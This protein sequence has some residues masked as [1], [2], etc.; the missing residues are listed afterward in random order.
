MTYVWV[1]QKDRREGRKRQEGREIY[2]KI[3]CK[4]FGIF[5]NRW[6]LRDN[7]HISVLMPEKKAGNYFSGS[8]WVSLNLVHS[9]SNTIR[10]KWK[11]LQCCSPLLQYFIL[12]YK[13]TLHLP[14]TIVLSNCK[15]CVNSHA[16]KHWHRWKAEI[17]GIITVFQENS[18]PSL[19]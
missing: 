2:W 5:V 3:F 4:E 15:F 6:G 14:H 11:L 1:G 12:K 19:M 13:N 18:S 9:R 7:F 10:V 16:T 17:N 8:R